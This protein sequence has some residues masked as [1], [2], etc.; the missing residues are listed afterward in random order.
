[1]KKVLVIDNDP[2]CLDMMCEALVYEGFEAKCLERTGDIL[3]DI[4]DFNPDLVIIDY[5]LNGING[6]ELC[7]QIK[8]NPKTSGV[9]VIITSAY[10]RVFQSIGR[11]EC[12]DF[13]SKP[14][15]LEDFSARIKGLLGHKQNKILHVI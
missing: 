6:G 5:I 7:S 10:P 4:E 8:R 11:Y 14:F 15:D 13:I 3:V 1:M 12:N 2:G 9:P